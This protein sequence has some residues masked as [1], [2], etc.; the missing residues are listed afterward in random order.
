MITNSSNIVSIKS[1]DELHRKL[2]FGKPKH[3]LISLHRY[4]NLPQMLLQAP[5]KLIT[6]LYQ[7][8]L[9][10]D[11]DCRL[12]YGQSEYDFNEGVLS[13]FMNTYPLAVKIKEYGFFHYSTNEALIMSEE[14]EHSMETIFLNLER[15]Y[16]LPIDN[17]TQ[18]V[19]INNIELLL[20]YANRYY[21]RQF[22][23]R[24]HIS[25][26]LLASVEIILNTYFSNAVNKGLPSMEWIAQQ[27]NLSPKYLSDSLKQLTGQSLQHHIHEKLIERAHELLGGTDL[28]IAEIAYQLGFEY[29][30]SFNK[31]FK[32]KTQQTP[33]Q[34]RKNLN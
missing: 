26:K 23:T 32:N 3:P 6:D 14:E 1:I 9:K 27:L 25:H 20:N 2:S 18:D 19:M 24:K 17:S 21:K 28:T 4:E 15:E 33:L 34:Y 5:L 7:I 16:Q 22:I 10:K 31:L 29:P 12:N 11:S 8:T 30:Q 13:F